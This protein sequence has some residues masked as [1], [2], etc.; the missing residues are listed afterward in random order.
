MGTHPGGVD[1][2]GDPSAVRARRLEH[3]APRNKAGLEPGERVLDAI[4][5]GA[6]A[7]QW[8]LAGARSE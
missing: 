6:P 8:P 3:A 1:S 4:A 7:A 5:S 2:A